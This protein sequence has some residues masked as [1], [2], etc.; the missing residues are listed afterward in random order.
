[1]TFDDLVIGG[2]G[3]GLLLLGALL[4][5]WSIDQPRQPIAVI[6]ARV[7]GAAIGLVLGIAGVMVIW[8]LIAARVMT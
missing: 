2:I 4:L 3:V 8:A 6:A 7:V 1:M 5:W